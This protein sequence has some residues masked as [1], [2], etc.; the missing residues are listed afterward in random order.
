MRELESDEAREALTSYFSETKLLFVECGL[1]K[2]RKVDLV[3]DGS[4]RD[5]GRHYAAC[6][7]DGRVILVSPAM[8]DLP[9]DSVAA[10][11]AHEFGH[12]ADFSYPARFLV[13]DGELV[14]RSGTSAAGIDDRWAYNQSKQWVERPDDA[15]ELT[16]D[17]IAEWVTGRQIRYSGSRCV[18]TYGAGVS[19]RPEGLE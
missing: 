8:A 13:A 4:V 3:V 17:L 12:A 10:I 19:P 16:A 18:Q 7:E 5:S 14:Q 9:H 2:L 15:V 1:T 11:F 6:R